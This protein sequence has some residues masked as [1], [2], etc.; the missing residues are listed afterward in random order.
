MYCLTANMKSFA[1][2]PISYKSAENKYL[3]VLSRYQIST[4][5]HCELC[6]TLFKYDNHVSHI[7][8]PH[9]YP[10][11]NKGIYSFTVYALILALVNINMFN[12][13]CNRRFIN[14][15]DRNIHLKICKQHQKIQENTTKMNLEQFKE[16]ISFVID[17]NVFNYN[18]INMINQPFDIFPNKQWISQQ[19]EWKQKK[20][21][22][23][24]K[25]TKLE[26]D[27]PKIKDINADEHKDLNITQS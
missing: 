23:R 12:T 2:K 24:R 9:N 17:E 25:E 3:P 4:Y 13:G 21:R 5:P 22:K 10:C 26:Q 6:F 18:D 27:P 14:K 11:H 1:N 16:C 8:I 15:R 20:H 7:Q 19:I